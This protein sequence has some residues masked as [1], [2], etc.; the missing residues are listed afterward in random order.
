MLYFL[1]LTQITLFMSCSFHKEE[2]F[3]R[4]PQYDNPRYGA[5]LM[6]LMFCTSILFNAVAIVTLIAVRYW[7]SLVTNR[8]L[9]ANMF[10]VYWYVFCCFLF[11]MCIW[12]ISQYSSP[13]FVQSVLNG[14]TIDW[15]MD[16][17]G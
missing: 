8:D 3:S 5:D 16:S 2:N 11:C 14:I 9:L 17:Y 13:F 4:Q 6:T 1:I 12:K 7:G 15:C 10:K